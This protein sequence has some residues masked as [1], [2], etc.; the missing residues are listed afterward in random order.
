MASGEVG[1]HCPACRKGFRAAGH[2]PGKTYACPR[3][4][5]PLEVREAE[6]DLAFKDEHPV[7][8]EI[9]VRLGRYLIDGEVARGGMGVVYKGRQEGLDRVVAIKLLLGGAAAD[10]EMVQRFHREGR[11]AAKLRHPNIVA[12]HEVGEYEGRPFFTMDFIE[13]KSLD[14][15]LQEGPLAF[16]RGARL[17]RDVARA[18][19]FAHQQGIIHRDLKPG[20]VLVDPADVPHVTDFGLAKDVGSK[21]MLSVTGEIMGTPAFMSPEQAEGRVHEL[22]RRSD[23]YSLGAILYRMLTGRPPF[24]GPTLAATIFKVVHE[25]T[26]EPVRLN[27]RVP[28]ELSA[29]C[30]KAL[31]KE[32]KDR[33][34]TAGEFADDLDRFLSGEPVK[35]KPLPAWGRLRRQMKR[36]RRVLLAAG[37]VGAAAVAALALVLAFAVR[38][39]IDLIEE[40]LARP[41]MRHVALK[42]LLEGMDRFR[43]RSRALAL[44]KGAVT[45]GT[46]DASRELA[47]AKPLAELAEAYAAHLPIEKPEKLRIRLIQALAQLKH[48]P[49]VPDVLEIVRS[50]KGEVRIAAIR[51]FRSVPDLGAFY[52]LGRL[53]ADPECGA[54]ARTSIQ[55]LYIDKVLAFFS[56]AAARTGAALA[57]LGVAVE[58]HNRQ[59]NEVLGSGAPKGPKD[60]VEAA[61]AEL[62]GTDPA[63]RMKG[64]YELG[65]SG[66]DRGREP[67][68]AAVADADDGVSRMAAAALERLGAAASKER[69]LELLKHSRAGVRRNAA[70]LLGKAGDRSARPAVEA[71]H[72]VESDA[73]AKYAMED[74]LVLLR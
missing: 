10:A 35:A 71:A 29:I 3:C 21:S 1:L 25:Y 72:R 56:P 30:M 51:F 26:R 59:V 22:D 13:G 48:R 23:V 28:P 55:R 8:R 58:A 11:A 63:R 74:A 36:N 5:G 43:D 32:P 68:L 34:A 62:R 4:K 9:P 45:R 15:V 16:D 52:D 57:E 40:N 37:S 65:E 6:P 60:A 19:H 27:P 50:T 46:D 24:E 33:Y 44:A 2:A 70:F 53:I 20:N 17:L 14:A 39:E 73:E 47:Y 67:L 54:E 49:A 61:I 7:P 41:E 31:E 66:D 38:S 42:S 69:I 12:I 64:A 18:V